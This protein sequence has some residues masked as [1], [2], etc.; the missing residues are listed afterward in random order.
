MSGTG[1]EFRPPR[2]RP[3]R[4][5]L[6]GVCKITGRGK[7]PTGVDITGDTK[8]AEEPV[9]DVSIVDA[10]DVVKEGRV[11]KRPR[12][13]WIFTLRPPHVYCDALRNA[14]K[15]SVRVLVR[16]DTLLTTGD[17]EPGDGLIG[18]VVKV[19]ATC[20][21]RAQEVTN[22]RANGFVLAATQRDRLVPRSGLLL[23]RLHERR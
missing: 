4:R 12:T 14:K 19:D 10:S 2:H 16:V 6:P 21:L 9:N 1:S 22:S 8:L 7:D 18:N 20:C 15:I 17:K 3:H 11:P 5:L 23:S 13:L